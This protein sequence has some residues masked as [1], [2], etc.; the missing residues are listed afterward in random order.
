MLLYFY[1]LL[2]DLLNGFYDCW[3][4]G[5]M[6]KF[7]L[8]CMNDLDIVIFLLF[9]RRSCLR[10]FKATITHTINIYKPIHLTS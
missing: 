5:Y 7:F 1:I 8:G 3:R 4:S 10:I 6:L 2:L 9:Q